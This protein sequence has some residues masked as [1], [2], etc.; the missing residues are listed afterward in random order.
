M[1]YSRVMLESGNAKLFLQS[2]EVVLVYLWRK[3]LGLG[4]SVFFYSSSPLMP[5]QRKSSNFKWLE[6]ALN[7]VKIKNPFGSVQTNPQ[8]DAWWVPLF[9]FLKKCFSGTP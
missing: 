7:L 9:I 2:V 8:A 1:V 4:P 5:I 6:A 3:Y